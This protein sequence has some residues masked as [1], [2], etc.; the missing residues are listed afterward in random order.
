MSDKERM[1]LVAW[2]WSQYPSAHRD[3][4]NLVIHIF[5]MP[6]FAASVLSIPFSLATG[7]YIAAAGAFGAMI[8][9]VAMQG[10]GHKLEKQP[11]AK[12]EGPIDFVRRFFSEQ[13]YNFP[14]YVFTGGWGR[15]FRSPD[16]GREASPEHP[17][18]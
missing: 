7:R 11:P 10:I 5:T 13:L 14:R 2:Q 17:P 16:H 12:I 4:R 8:F 3:R 1:G 9:V 18:A 15:A 6:I